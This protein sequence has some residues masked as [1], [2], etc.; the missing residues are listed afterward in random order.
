MLTLLSRFLTRPFQLPVRKLNCN[1][2]LKRA[3][4]LSR[5]FTFYSKPLSEMYSVEWSMH[6]YVIV[7]VNENLP[8]C[9]RVKLFFRD[10]LCVA[11]LTSLSPRIDTLS[12][13][14]KLLVGVTARI[15]LFGPMQANINMVRCEILGILPFS[16][17]IG[18]DKCRIVLAQQ[19]DKLL[20]KETWMA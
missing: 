6:F 14:V 19:G 18:K 17:R 11:G 2:V 10:L 12:P 3:L 1:S 15:K 4:L 20:T 7:E 5:A 13:S 8:L 9:S 16:C